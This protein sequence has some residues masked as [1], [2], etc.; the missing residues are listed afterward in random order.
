VRAYSHLLVL[1]LERGRLLRELNAAAARLQRGGG[2]GKAALE[3]SNV[4]EADLNRLRSELAHVQA[5]ILAEEARAGSATVVS[6]FLTFKDEP[7]KLACLDAAAAAPVFFPADKADLFRGRHRL[8]V[9][10]APEPS[11]V[12]YENIEFGPAARASRAAAVTCVVLRL[13]PRLSAPP[14]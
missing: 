1:V 9:T 12:L 4:M 5:R 3:V 10:D 8:H 7:Y 14:L 2:S 11:D 6:A 13:S